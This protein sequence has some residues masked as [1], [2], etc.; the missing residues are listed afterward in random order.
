MKEIELSHSLEDYLE[1]IFLIYKKKKVVRVKD[2]VLRQNVKNASVIKAVKK[3]EQKGFINHEHY[4]YIELTQSGKKKAAG[5]Y[6]K[7]KALFTFL[8]EV[9]DLDEETAET[10]ACR[11]E[12]YISKETLKRLLKLIEFVEYC[13]GCYPKWSKGLK[14]FINTGI[15]PNC[16]ACKD[17]F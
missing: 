10:D 3:L 17:R 4:G 2:L 12:H 16:D 15:R 8:T 6:E 13:P 14:E 11:M 5:I 9:L 1:A 7:H